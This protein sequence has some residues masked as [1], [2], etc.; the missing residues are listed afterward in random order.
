MEGISASMTEFLLV[1][2]ENIICFL[3]F[4]MNFGC[5]KK[6]I[7]RIVIAFSISTTLIYFLGQLFYGSNMLVFLYYLLEFYILMLALNF[8]FNTTRSQAVCC[9]SL[10][11]TTQHLIYQILRIGAVWVAPEKY[12]QEG[13]WYYFAG[14]V[15][16]YLPFCFVIYYFFARK[17]SEIDFN[18]HKGEIRW[19]AILLSTVMVLICIGLTRL[20]KGNPYKSTMDILAES[21]YSIICCSLC[22][23]MQ[24]EFNQRAKLTEEVEMVRMLWQK[25]SKQLAERK[26]IIELVNMKCHDIR[27]R[28]EDY[29]LPLSQ[30][31]RK[32]VESLIRIYDQTYCTGNQTL[33]VLLAD[34]VLLCEK[35]NIQLTFLG[36]GDWLLFITESDLYSL[37]GNALSNAI[38][39]VRLVEEEKRQ[40]SM[41]IRKSGDLI[42]ISVTNYYT[43]EIKFEDEMP[44]TSR[45]DSQDFH[46]YGMKSMRAIAKKY[47]GQIKVKAENGV[48]TL[49]IWLV[50]PDETSIEKI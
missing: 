39:A 32:N 31:E 27:H 14:A 10:G 43:G 21:L 18:Y 29:Y 33:D 38:E 48:F 11:R 46:G 20:V 34:R 47:S 28:L 26:N 1:Y 17:I 50:K 3:S 8:V 2:I 45:L 49:T 36:H 5:R 30:E 7:A 16:S 42:C 6:F 19:K 23:L 35:D 41:I 44:I 9:A 13:T 24:I 37:L 25:D 15:L 4:F 40:I 22:L 12:F